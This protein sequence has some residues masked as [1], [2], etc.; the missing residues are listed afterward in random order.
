[1]EN[2]NTPEKK[3]LPT[4]PDHFLQYLP[5]KRIRIVIGIIFLVIVL[6]L[7]KNPIL[8]SVSLLTKKPAEQ[9]VPVL[10]SVINNETSG[11]LSIDVDSDGDGLADW[12][13]TLIGTDPYVRNNTTDVPNAIRELISLTSEN[14]VTTEDKL[15]LKVYQRLQ[16]DPKGTNIAEAIQ[17]ATVKEVLDLADSL[18]RQLTTYTFDD[19]DIIDNSP[20]ANAI[21]KNQIVAFRKT[22]NISEE[23]AKDIYTLLFTGERTINITTFQIAISQSITKLLQTPV[24]IIIADQH[25]ILINA[26]AH[27][28]DVL[29][30]QQSTTLEESLQFAFFLIY[31][32]NANVVQ[33]TNDIIIQVL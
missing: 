11:K 15:A 32:K 7:L 26:L 27:I 29:G 28:N 23:T 2:N 17:A 22:L 12:Q 1:M 30:S 14:I 4:N 3:Q 13:E 18:D 10:T 19:L 25:L 9:S 5:S 8:R 24:P 31:Q 33:Q 16:T 21:Y 20:Q 6:L